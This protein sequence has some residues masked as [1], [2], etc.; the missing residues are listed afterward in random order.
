M[1]NTHFLRN[2][3]RWKCGLPEEE[4]DK[5]THSLE[6]LQRTEWS[7]EFEHLMRNRLIMGALRYGCMGHGSVPKGKPVYD[8]CESI[9]QRLLR[10][11]TTGNAEWLVD[12]ANMALLMFEERVHPRHNFTHIDGDADS[13]YH[14]RVLTNNNKK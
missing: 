9:R 12:I 11:E 7:T 10:Y 2:L 4:Y 1:D 6:Q 8:R 5:P 13:N 14:D 3:W